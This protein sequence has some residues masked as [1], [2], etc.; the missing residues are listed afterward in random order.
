MVTLS[1]VLPCPEQ[2]QGRA[3]K[4]IK[5]LREK[6]TQQQ[7]FIEPPKLDLNSENESEEYDYTIKKG[8]ELDRYQLF[9]FDK[10]KVTKQ[11]LDFWKNHLETFPYLSKYARSI[12][13]IPATTTQVER[14]FSTAG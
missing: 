9:E 1:C 10:N 2:E 4:Q 12:F 7:H 3:G 6:Q 5:K 11:P 13:S 8:D 14:E